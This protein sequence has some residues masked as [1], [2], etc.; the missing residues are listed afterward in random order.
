VVESSG[1]DDCLLDPRSGD[2]PSVADVAGPSDDEIEAMVIGGPTVHD[3]TIYLAEYDEA[4]ITLFEREAARI[5]GA[6]G[7]AAVAVEHVG[8]TS[9]PGLAAKPI[10]DIVLVVSD[11]SDEDAY[12]PALQ[13]VGY[14]LRIREA[15]WFEHRLFKG[16]G[17]DVNVHVF[18][19]GCPEIRRMVDFRDH[20]RRDDADR[21]L[22]E[23]AKRRLAAQRWRYVQH[24]ANAKSDV[25]QEIMSRASRAQS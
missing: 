20:L 14:V 11:S 6:L 19:A 9:V 3:D 8:S 21:R 25:V 13:D 7:A 1:G 18:S 15:S 2:C 23:H 24:Y 16:P 17:T 4:W 10:I 12:L 5:R 22:Y